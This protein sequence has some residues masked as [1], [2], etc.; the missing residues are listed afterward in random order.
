MTSPKSSKMPSK[1]TAIRGVEEIR[2]F[3][4]FITSLKDIAF[5]VVREYDRPN[6]EGDHFS[7]IDFDSREPKPTAEKIIFVFPDLQKG[8]E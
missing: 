1:G 6:F 3:G 5:V 4:D 7:T 8:R 2:D